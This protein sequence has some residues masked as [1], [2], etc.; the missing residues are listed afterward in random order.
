MKQLCDSFRV[1][2][3]QLDVD[4]AWQIISLLISPMQTE[5]VSISFRDVIDFLYHL[6][7]DAIFVYMN[8]WFF[9]EVDENTRW[10]RGCLKPFFKYRPKSVGACY[11]ESSK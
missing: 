2:S 1:F 11:H 4:I 3:G 6:V 5:W 9:I 7:D 8:A 10:L